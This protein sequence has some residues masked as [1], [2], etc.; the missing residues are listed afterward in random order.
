MKQKSLV[1]TLLLLPLMVSAQFYNPYNPYNYNQ[2]QAMQDAYNMGRAAAERDRQA[3]LNN[4]NMLW[5]SIV[6]N[7][8]KGY[9]F[10]DA[11]EM[12]YEQAEHLASTHDD[13][14]GYLM[15]GYMSEMGIGTTRNRLYAKMCYKSGADLGNKICKREWNR[16]NEGDYY[17]EDNADAFK[18]YY[19][20]LVN[21][22]YSAAQSLNWNSNSGRYS[23]ERTRHSNRN[24]RCSSCG[25]TGVNPAPNSGGSLVSWVAHYNRRGVECRYCG[26]YSEHYHDRCASCNVPKY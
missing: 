20:Q 11:Y 21:S 3:L 15:Q 7:L 10:P 6:E 9:A 23:Q 8:G 24:S 4:P 5:A 19:A 17:D 1:L 2:Q 12:A 26:R 14:R 16:C 22:A 13:A 18:L 25:G